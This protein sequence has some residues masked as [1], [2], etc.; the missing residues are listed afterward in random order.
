MRFL[1]TENDNCT[2]QTGTLLLLS[3]YGEVIDHAEL[4]SM[5]VPYEYT[6]SCE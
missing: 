6:R 4:A 2:V 3:T 5:L 1:P